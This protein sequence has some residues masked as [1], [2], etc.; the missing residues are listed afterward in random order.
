MS[1][2]KADYKKILDEFE[3]LADAD[4]M[5]FQERIIPGADLRYGVRMP[6]IKRIGK[7]IAK[8]D[9][10]GF[11]SLVEQGSFEESA[12][13]AYVLAIMKTDVERRLQYIKD[14]IPHI[15]NWSVCDTLCMSYKPKKADRD[16]VWAFMLPYFTSDAEFSIRFALVLFLASFI[17]EEH[18]SIGL[19]LLE[20]VNHEAYY[21]KM[22]VAWA[23]SICF[24]KFRNETLALIQKQA[25]D[26]FTQNKAIQKIRESYRVSQE[27]KDMLLK[28]KL[29]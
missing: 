20:E 27:D 9:A 29:N 18:I 6:E 23:V 12:L 3:L 17:D 14:F 25:L 16:A 19:S 5:R 28:Y 21:V 10:E 26:K 11:L 15:N 13:T 2:T 8:N 22:A 4:Y 1:F 7:Q 24:I